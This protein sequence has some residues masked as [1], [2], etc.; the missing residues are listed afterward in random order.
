MLNPA[1]SS[2]FF[3]LLFLAQLHQTISVGST[4]KIVILKIISDLLGGNSEEISARGKS[5]TR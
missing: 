1:F 2:L 4:Q 3:R 5:L